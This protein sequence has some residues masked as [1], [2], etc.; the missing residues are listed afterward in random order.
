MPYVARLSSVRHSR[1]RF[2]LAEFELPPLQDPRDSWER[3][4][5]SS[6]AY[7]GYHFSSTGAGPRDLIDKPFDQDLEFPEGGRRAWLVVLGSWCGLFSS[8]GLMNTMGVFQEYILMHQLKHLDAA[9]VGWIFSLYAFCTFGGGLFVGP[10]FD[11]YG[12]RWLVLAGSV[13]VVLSMDLI[14]SCI[15][16]WPLYFIVG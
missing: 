7:G 13:L 6:T 8:L 15:G 10:L 5:S 11:N 9:T 2:S 1:N 4:F 3:A 12:P 14:G 16:E